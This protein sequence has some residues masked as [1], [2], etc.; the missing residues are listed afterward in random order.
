MDSRRV[1]REREVTRRKELKMRSS[2]ERGP[3]QGAGFAWPNVRE[4][5]VSERRDE[6][7]EGGDER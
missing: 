7:G 4:G 1:R 2:R 3:D 6:K 5:E